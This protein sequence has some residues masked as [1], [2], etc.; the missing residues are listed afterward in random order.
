MEEHQ[1][2]RWMSWFCTCSHLYTANH[3]LEVNMPAADLDRL[4]GLRVGR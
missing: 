3:M 4:I 1:R 2:R